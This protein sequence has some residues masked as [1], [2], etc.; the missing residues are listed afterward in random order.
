MKKGDE[1]T[2]NFSNAFAKLLRV[3]IVLLVLLL[4]IDIWFLLAGGA[5]VI[6]DFLR[7]L[8]SSYC[9]QLFSFWCLTVDDIYHAYFTLLGRPI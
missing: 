9:L 1:K 6:M 8:F 3:V 7:S 2:S 5:V 4:V